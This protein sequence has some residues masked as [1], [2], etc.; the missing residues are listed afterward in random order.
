[1][2]LLVVRYRCAETCPP[3]LRKLPF[4][5]LEAPRLG[6]WP[7][8]PGTHRSDS[9]IQ[10]KIFQGHWDRGQHAFGTLRR[11]DLCEPV[12][13]RATST[14]LCISRA[15]F[16][17]FLLSVASAVRL[18]AGK[19]RKHTLVQISILGLP[20]TPTHLVLGIAA[21]PV[22]GDGVFRTPHAEFYRSSTHGDATF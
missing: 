3:A 8:C 10:I 21:Y 17:S 9:C 20:R 7:P 18:N 12:N 2:Q 5:T 6:L 19:P 22:G 11:W 14:N 13:L 16:F 15:F 4:M 1:M